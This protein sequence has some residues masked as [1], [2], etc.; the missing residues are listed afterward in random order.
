MINDPHVITIARELPHAQ[1]LLSALY[2]CDYKA[3]FQAVRN[4]THNYRFLPCLFSKQPAVKSLTFV[5]CF[6]FYIK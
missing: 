4:V 6:H 5:V 1:A 2:Q 3:F